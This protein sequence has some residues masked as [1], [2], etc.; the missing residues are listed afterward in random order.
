MITTIY[1]YSD[2][3]VKIEVSDKKIA[4]INVLVLSGDEVIS[5]V[6]E[7]GTME[8][9]DASTA[10]C[11]NFYDG[12]YTVTGENIQKWLYFNPTGSDTVSYERRSVFR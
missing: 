12:F 4:C 2:N 1:D 9:F 5:V 3:A 8:N 11:M 7:D 10:R 6:F